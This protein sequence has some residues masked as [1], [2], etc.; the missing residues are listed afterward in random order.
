MA[1]VPVPGRPRPTRGKSR[2]IH[3]VKITGTES[4]T[5]NWAPQSRRGNGSRRSPRK[6]HMGE[7]NALQMLVDRQ[8]ITEVLYKYARAIDRCDLELLKS[9]FHSDSTHDHGEF[10]GK[11]LE[12]CD[13]AIERVQRLT[14]TQHHI[15]NILIDLDGDFARSETYWVAYHRIPPKPSDTDVS[16]GQSGGTDLFIGGRYLDRMA[17]RRGAWKITRRV[18]VHDWQRFEVP[19]DG[20]FFSSDPRKRGIR[21]R[22]DL[23]YW[24]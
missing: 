12:F 3:I 11:S 10:V 15:G 18:G 13:W 5:R 23:S 19:S 16:A 17:R 20:G 4:N 22:A 24:H 7:P 14:A 1:P 8:A 21:S 9:C 6:D 2:G